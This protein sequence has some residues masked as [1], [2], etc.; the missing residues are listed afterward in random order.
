[1]TRYAGKGKPPL[2]DLPSSEGA[3]EKLGIAYLKEEDHATEA[4]FG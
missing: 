3:E 1:L 2:I 4:A